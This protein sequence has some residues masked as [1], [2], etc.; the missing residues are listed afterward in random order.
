M[1]HLKVGTLMFNWILILFS[2][3]W[4]INLGTIGMVQTG[5]REARTGV[6]KVEM[7][8]ETNLCI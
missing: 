5:L 6:T 8:E 7:R 4:L 1:E 2:A 3:G